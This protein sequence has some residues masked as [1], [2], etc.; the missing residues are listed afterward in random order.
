MSKRTRLFVVV[1]SG[2]L[3]IGVGTVGVASYVGLAAIGLNA[4]G[5]GNDLSYVPGSA[6][7]VAY[8]DVRRLMDSEL[9]RTLQPE[10]KPPSSQDG[11]FEQI[12]LNLETDVDSVL[13]ASPGAGGA[14]PA[15]NS[16]LII[17]RGRFD[18]GRIEAAV[19]NDGGSPTDYRGTRLVANEKVAVAFVD[20]GF[21]VAGSPAL[22]RQALDTKAG[23][24]S[25]TSDE[26]LMRLV[27]R[28]E[29][30]DTWVVANFEALQ[31]AH[32]L[33]GPV[34][35]QLPALTWL[36]ASGQV[37]DNVTARVFAEGRDERAAQDL[38]DVVR[39]FVALARMQTGQQAAFAEVLNSVQLT[40]EGKTVTL[41]FAVPVQFFERLKSGLP[42]FPAPAAPSSGP[43]VRTSRPAARPAA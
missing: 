39:G 33:P 21:I 37:G 18:A 43:S 35:G 25:V 34:A 15:G 28:V 1:A 16:G 42:F 22:V 14:A 32:S 29:D 26:S 8:A 36:A 31:A 30:A 7:F 12:G 9:R 2:A 3:V 4:G 40:G 41:S 5:P 10:V 38:R 24:D 6:Q 27:H 19:R 13:V 20:T 23:S 11:P 17:A